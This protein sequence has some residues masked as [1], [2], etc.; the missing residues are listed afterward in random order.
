MSTLDAALWI[1]A[2][3]IVLLFATMALI[4]GLMALM[5]RIPGRKATEPEAAKVVG[6]QAP[7]AAIVQ[8]ETKADKSKAAAAAVAVALALRKAS[9]RLAPKTGGVVSTP[10]QSAQRA[11][12]ISRRNQLISRK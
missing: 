1:S 11:D 5:A 8:L 2:I 3:S 6:E 9:A 7:A 12:Q 4:W 10:W